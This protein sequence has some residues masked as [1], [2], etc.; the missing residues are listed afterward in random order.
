MIKILKRPS[1]NEF[2]QINEYVAKT[3]PMHTHYHSTNPFEK[4]LWQQKKVSIKS[5]LKKLDIKTVLDLGC[6]DAGMLDSI[7]KHV[8]YTG[9][10]ISPT[11]LEYAN[12]YAK[13]IKRNN[14]RLILGDILNLKEIKNSSYDVTI[15]C[16]V[17]EH[18]LNPQKLLRESK[19]VTKKGGFIIFSIPNEYMLEL[20]RAL[21]LRF[22]LRSPDHINALSP[23]D[24]EDIF[25]KVIAQKNIPLKFSSSL[26]LIRLLFVQ[27][28]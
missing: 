28:T 8:N 3:S 17:V 27:K 2:Y 14:I 15:V 6:G 11:Q 24:I 16:D 21:L 5:F 25:P 23:K 19:R 22:P 26:S 4:W 12:K 9:I 7:D 18:V 1:F 13:K 20:T 10:D